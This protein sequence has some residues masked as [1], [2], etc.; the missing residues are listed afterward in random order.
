MPQ[1]ASGIKGAVARRPIEASAGATFQALRL[2]LSPK[3]RGP[4]ELLST[5]VSHMCLMTHSSCFRAHQSTPLGVSKA[6]TQHRSSGDAMRLVSFSWVGA[7]LQLALSL[8]ELDGIAVSKPIPYPNHMYLFLK[9]F[10]LL[11]TAC[12]SSISLFIF[13]NQFADI[14]FGGIHLFGAVLAMRLRVSTLC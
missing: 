12:I 5:G 9:C 1:R 13:T 6:G 14:Q 2:P 10:S 3:G 11:L 8:Y 7:P 4:W